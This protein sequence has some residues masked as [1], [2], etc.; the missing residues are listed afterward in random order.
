MFVV[1]T[2][3]DTV[4]HQFETR[5]LLRNP[6]LPYSIVRRSVRDKF[7]QH[8]VMFRLHESKRWNVEVEDLS[9]PVD[10][11]MVL[12]LRKDGV[13]GNLRVLALIVAGETHLVGKGVNYTKPS[14]MSE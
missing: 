2:A 14:C 7:W 9:L 4:N 13:V 3:Y 10:E 6:Q 12:R 11:I 5:R 1:S 8:V